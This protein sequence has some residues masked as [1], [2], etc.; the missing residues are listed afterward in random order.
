MPDTIKAILIDDELSS[1]QNLRQKL[2][3]FCK[4]VQVIATAQ[5]PEEAMLLIRHHKPDLLFLDIEMPRMSGFRMLEELGDYDADIIFTTAYNH[6]AI[7]AMR[8][9]AFDYLVKPIAIADL[10]NAVN[11]LLLIRAR[12]TRER[13][14]V[15]RDSM[16]EA[17]TQ[18]NKIAV[19]TSEGLEFIPIRNIIRIESS[20]N[21]SKVFLAAGQ[22]LLVTRLL[23]DFEDVLLPYK[24]FRV[25][26]CHLVNLQYI[27]R[28]IRGEGGQVV[29]ENGDVVDVSRRKKDEFL[30]LFQ[31]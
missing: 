11:R 24:F 5:K 30:S 1:L 27:T 6:Y 31:S 17:K 16:S 21:Y 22:V 7:D 23:K 15:L 19:P 20:S 2:E 29:M 25:H 13:L 18:D 9:S 28:Y 10:Q 8:I 3:E 26:N 4:P 14:H 12:Q